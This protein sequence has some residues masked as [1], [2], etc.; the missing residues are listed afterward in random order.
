M[1]ASWQILDGQ[2]FAT[3]GERLIVELAI[4]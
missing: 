3:R 4:M 2:L 1:S